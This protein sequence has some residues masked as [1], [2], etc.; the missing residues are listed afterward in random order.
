VDHAGISQSHSTSQP[1]KLSVKDGLDFLVVEG[2]ADTRYSI[3]NFH[4]SAHHPKINVPDSAL[5]SVGYTHNTFVMETLI[6]ELAT[7]AK[8]DPIRYRLTLLDAD[9]KKLRAALTLLQER[10]RHG[11]T[12]FRETMPPGSPAASITEQPSGA[13]STSRSKAIGREFIA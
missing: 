4:V 1:A 9:A 13:P 7:R 3:P 11:V 6:D 2:S 5:R 8:I 10:V 12:T